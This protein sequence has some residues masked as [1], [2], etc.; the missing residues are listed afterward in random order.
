L[1]VLG[2]GT[3]KGDVRERFE[4]MYGWIKLSYP[5]PPHQGPFYSPSIAEIGFPSA[6]CHSIPRRAVPRLPPFEPINSRSRLNNKNLAMVPAFSVT[7][8]GVDI[9]PSFYLVSHPHYNIVYRDW[10][11]GKLQ[12]VWLI[13]PEGMGS[14]L[15]RVVVI[16]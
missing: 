1:C 5:T 14:V 10:A 4:L 15:Y 9:N 13:D 3:E 12:A 8:A 2:S 7:G 16:Y 6:L 11:E